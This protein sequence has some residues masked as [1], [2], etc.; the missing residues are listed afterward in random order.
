MDAQFWDERYRGRDRLF[1]GEANV[2]LVAEAAGLRPGRAL[3]VGCGEGADAVWLAARGWRVRAV[4]IAPTALERARLAAEAAGVG[5]RVAWV[6]ADV[7]LAPP[8]RGRSIWCRRSIFR[9]CARR[10]RRRWR[11]WWGR[12]LP[13]GCCWWS[14]MT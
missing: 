9:C 12:S 3:D 14:G 1:S 5:D 11:A 2:V 4:D 7:S 6:R 13:V 10:V 8:R